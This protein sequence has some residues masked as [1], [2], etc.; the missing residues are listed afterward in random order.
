MYTIKQA[1]TLTGVPADTMRAWE[2]R[3]ALPA[4]HRSP[5]GYRLYDPA[6]LE[7]YRRMRALIG[8]GWAARQ[9]AAL[10]TGTAELP[11][12]VTFVAQ[13]ARDGRPRPGVC[14]T[15]AAHFSPTAFPELADEWL[16]PML[17]E[18]GR[19]WA[20]G[21]VSIGLEH[22]LSAVLMRQLSIA[23][24]ERSPGRDA[25][26]LVGLPAGSWHELALMSFA[27][28]LQDRGVAVGYLGPNLPLPSWIEAVRGQRPRA[29]VTVAYSSADRAR[30]QELAEALDELDQPPQVWVGGPQ[31]LGSARALGGGLAAAAALVAD[32]VARSE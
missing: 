28:L 17:A 22:Q 15:L 26:V 6:G 2:R 5:S 18:V 19:A 25:E 3:Y 20:A 16:M 9:A 14:A 13:L 8:D 30:V 10:V 31:S 7:P 1:A 11:D 32:Q 24:E 4:P 12:P 21:E 27:V 23:F 29:V